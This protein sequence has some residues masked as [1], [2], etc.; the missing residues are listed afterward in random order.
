MKNAMTRNITIQ[1]G[2]GSPVNHSATAKGICDTARKRPK[3]TAPATMKKIMAEVRTVSRRIRIIPRRLSCRLS[4][5]ITR[6][7]AAPIAAASIGVNRP[8]NMPPITT[9]KSSSVSTTPLRDLSLS[10]HD[11]LGPGGPMA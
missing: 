7:P 10:I 1:P 11:I 3:T 5:A 6:L 8:T 4:A 2:R 9:R